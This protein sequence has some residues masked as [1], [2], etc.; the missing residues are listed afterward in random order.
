MLDPETHAAVVEAVITLTPND[1]TIL[2][3]IF[4]TYV[5]VGS[6]LVEDNLD[7]IK[8]LPI[9]QGLMIENRIWILIF[10]F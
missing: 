2:K 7:S 5:T 1:N 4:F 6:D 3:K 9:I 8:L 10:F